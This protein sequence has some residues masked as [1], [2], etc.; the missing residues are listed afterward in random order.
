MF[1]KKK[2]QP[3]S[4]PYDRETQEPVIR[5]SICTGEEVAGFRDR[6]TGRFREFMLLRSPKDLQEFMETWGLDTEPPRIY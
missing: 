5:C 6:T 3:R 4:L 1:L 2:K